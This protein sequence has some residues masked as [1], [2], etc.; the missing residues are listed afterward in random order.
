MLYEREREEADFANV[1]DFALQPAQEIKET[2]EEKNFADFDS[3]AYNN[4]M[5]AVR[6]TL[7]DAGNVAETGEVETAKEV[8][9]V[10]EVETS[11][12]DLAIET[13]AE[14][15]EVQE[16]P[17][18]QAVE[19]FNDKEEAVIAIPVE[20][21][22]KLIPMS[23]DII[24]SP[25][26]IMDIKDT[27]PTRI[28]IEEDVLV[29]DVK[30]DL[31]NILSMDGKIRLAEKEIQIG[32]N[33]GDTIKVSGDLVIQTLYIPE[34]IADVDAIVA[35]ESRISFKSDYNVGSTPG[36]K[37][38]MHPT[39]E[40]IEFT[41]INER[42]FKVKA[43]VMLCGKE[44]KNLEMKIFEGVRD[45]DV[46][47]LKEKINITDVALRKTD[48]L[49]VKEEFT[50][51]D[52]Q[53]AIS[54][55]LKHDIS[56]IENNKQILKDKA[57]INGTLF[58]NVLYIGCI[59]EDHPEP[60][61]TLYQGKVDF[62]HFVKLNL[63]DSQGAEPAGG[64]TSFNIKNFSLS[65][66]ENENDNPN[67]FIL[68]ADIETAIEVYRNIEKEV[69]TDIYHSQKDMNYDTEELCLRTLSG[70]GN[71]EV[72][73]REMITVPE[74]MGNVE[75]VAFISSDI[76]ETNKIVDDGRNTIEGTMSIN[77]ICI[78]EDKEKAPFSITQEIPFRSVVEIPSLASDM[79]TET[80]MAQK[81][82]WFDR[83]S[84]KQIEINGN[85]AIVVSAYCEEKHNIVRSVVMVEGAED[86]VKM[87]GLVL[88]ITKSG[89]N[90]WKIAK[91]FRTTIDAIKDHN[92]LDFS[93][94]LTPGTKLLIETKPN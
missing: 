61:P 71:S 79:L 10:V 43:T 59:S 92:E 6:E 46:Q 24:T 29:P 42:K 41:R 12:F 66:K 58:C 34:N 37:I 88:Y 64:K 47:M 70:G 72:S 31:L 65:L 1:P 3:E 51:K 25:L 85:I 68:E 22:L 80:N 17:P 28:Y 14:A 33:G 76:K 55:I 75:K 77:L 89:D 69:V 21:P 39:V 73:I 67:T 93:S 36:S 53:P 38:V 30:P 18:Q 32:Q 83:I 82:L 7:S 50:V 63:D 27:V 4:L 62:T 26:K 9:E 49:E 56:L 90:I 87:P 54:K 15:E 8:E 94:K 74:N 52:T 11:P 5:G 23:G 60:Q 16:L 44:Y 45:E 40:N 35:I 84:D 81:A 48:E 19:V 78:P 13:V 91:K 86:C 20:K 57:V 2:V